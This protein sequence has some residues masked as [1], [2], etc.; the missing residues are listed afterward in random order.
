MDPETIGQSES[1]SVPESSGMPSEPQSSGGEFTGSSSP[2]TSGGQGGQSSPQQFVAAP[3]Q[4]N[5]VPNGYGTSPASVNAPPQQPQTPQQQQYTVREAI[6]RYGYDAQGY[7]NDAEAIRD[8]VAK[9]QQSQQLQQMAQYG[10]Q[11]L[12]HAG[13]FNNWLKEKQAAEAAKAAPAQESW[14]KAPEFDPE[15]RSKV[16]RDSNGNLTTLPGAPPDLINKYSSAIEHRD[17]FLEQFAFDPVGAIKPGIEEVAKGLIEKILGERDNQQQVQTFAKDYITQ[18]SSWLHQRDQQGKL[19]YDRATGK[20]ALA[21]YGKAFAH[22][23][24]QAAA[25]GIS[26]ENQRA[27]YAASMVQRDYL[28]HQ[29]QREAQQNAQYR[30]YYHQSMMQQ[31]AAQQQAAQQAAQRQQGEQQKQQFVQQAPARQGNAL[32]RIGNSDAAALS[33]SGAV[34]NKALNLAQRMR[35][36]LEANGVSEGSFNRS[37]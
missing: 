22:Y 12:Q 13:D 8:L 26:N 30:D 10:N 27:S 24:Q 29:A 15:W 7:T 23:V 5:G 16:V 28:K 20:P 32:S 36:S 3:N 35:Q 2:E 6:A 37:R 34:K 21:P 11:Y 19:V 1:S 33:S 14:W 4:R 25:T 17:K 31:Q 9:A 18:N